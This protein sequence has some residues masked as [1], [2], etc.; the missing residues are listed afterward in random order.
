MIKIVFQDNEVVR[1]REISQNHPHPYIRIKASALVLKSQN[2]EHYKIAASIGV[3]ENTLRT[4]FNQHVKD[5]I[6]S[7]TK[8]NFRKPKS[9]LVE[10]EEKI[11]NYL[12]KTPPA[13]I[14]QAC[15]E[16]EKLTKIKLR[17][18][19]MRKYLKSL[20][21][22]FRKVSSIPA[23]ADAEKQK[24]FLE[25]KLQP[26]LDEAKDGKR[27]V[28]FV[29]AAH[30]V[31][32]AFLG[33]LWS[34]TRIFVKTPSGRQRFNVLGALNA[35]SKEL[36]TIT[37][38]TYIT[39]TQVCELLKKIALTSQNPITLVLDNARYQRCDLV[40]NLANELGIELLFLPSYS[41]NLNLIERVWKFTK[42]HCLNS[43]Y[44][45]DFNLFK[46]A[47]SGF[48]S[49]MHHAHTTELKSLLSLEFQLFS[50][51][52]IDNAISI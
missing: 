52:Q 9:K 37:N 11:K 51:E 17:E 5:G 32:G 7:I 20:G 1:L 4:Y 16:I 31:L 50:K 8:L 26:R 33:F 14:K 34:F 19:Q 28:Y 46:N 47:I 36:I 22:K 43:K 48:L 3:S 41:P 2:I 39:S 10:F 13:S 44:Y 40:I 6:D 29:D 12:N 25:T 45:S 35:I 30:F 21:V 23:K 49:G 42:K 18:T 38:T 15:E 27:D 24:D